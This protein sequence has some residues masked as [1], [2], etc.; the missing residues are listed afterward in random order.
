MI[1]FVSLML[2][3]F[4]VFLV[5]CTTGNIVS[6]LEPVKE[7]P[8]L[9][10]NVVDGDTLDLEDGSRVRLSGINTPET[11][12]CYYDEAKGKLADLVLDEW[13]Y[14][15]RDVSDEG[16]YG[17]LLR[18]I[19][20]DDLFVNGFLVKEGYAVV[21]DKYK[22]DTRR[23]DEL[24]N[25]E[26]VAVDNFLGV[27]SCVDPKDGCM[28]VSSV[29]S[30]KYHKPDCKYAKKISE[31]NLVCFHSLEEVLGLEPCGSCIG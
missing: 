6:D 17:R 3:I 19:Y 28:F 14:L 15:E 30:D 12:E 26:L 4:L 22:D 23:Y 7:G 20:L 13:V 8:F 1:K 2:L 24:K 29:N 27:W 18:Y 11:G 25:Y 16:K 31:E 21:Y 10:V 5:G 9:V